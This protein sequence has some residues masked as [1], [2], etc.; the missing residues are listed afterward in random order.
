[1]TSD[2][3]DRAAVL[4]DRSR[5]RVFTAITSA[6][7][8]VGVAEL[9]EACGI[10]PNTVRLHLDRLKRAGLVTMADDGPRRPGRPPHRYVAS[11]NDP[12]ADA[13]AYRRLA[14]MLAKAVREGAGARQTGRAMAKSEGA[15]KEADG[16]AAIASAMAAQGFRPIIEPAGER[17]EIVLQTCPFAEVAAQDPATICQ[18]HLGLAEGTA[19]A[20]G[21]VTVERLVVRDPR[22]AGCRLVLHPHRAS[23]PVSR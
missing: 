11:G 2:E 12:S 3:G 4:A 1:M 7:A 9:A 5:R 21:G 17:T 18:L 23:R 22:E 10:H 16:L 19:E 13:D 8:P 6:A 15:P 20:V 14:G